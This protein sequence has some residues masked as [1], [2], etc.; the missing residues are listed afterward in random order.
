MDEQHCVPRWLR[1]I[2]NELGV[3]LLNFT[4]NGTFTTL[5]TVVARFETQ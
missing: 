2:G 4:I 5:V 1:D 3:G